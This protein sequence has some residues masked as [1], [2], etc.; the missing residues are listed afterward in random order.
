MGYTM[1]SIT[2]FLDG[3]EQAIKSNHETFFPMDK[4]ERKDMALYLAR[5]LGEGLRGYPV[6]EA[7]YEVAALYGRFHVKHCLDSV[8][9]VV[10]AKEF[11]GLI[12][13]IIMRVD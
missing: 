9:P 1:V 13:D 11:N 2:R 4:E 12:Y 5:G 8:G 10:N 7:K 6:C 3:T